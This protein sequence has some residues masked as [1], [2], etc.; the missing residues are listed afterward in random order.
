MFS[1]LRSV[2]LRWDIQQQR[3]KHG[4]TGHNADTY[5]GEQELFVWQTCAMIFFVIFFFV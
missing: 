5:S 4:A 3:R 2:Y 1:I